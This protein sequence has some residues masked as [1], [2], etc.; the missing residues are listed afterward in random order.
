VASGLHVRLDAPLPAELAVGA[1]S[2]VFVAGTCHAGAVPVSAIELLVDGEPQPVMAHGMPRIDVLREAGAPAAYRSG[3]WA[4]ARLRPRA[5]AAPRILGIRARLRDG[6]TAEAEL[7]RIHADALPAPVAPAAR[8]PEVAICMATY[9]PPLALFRA[10]IESIRAQTH[11]DWLCVISDDGSSPA[12]RATI[13][14]VVGEDPR[15]V[16]TRAPRRLGFYRNFER[17]LA[18][19]PEGARYVALAD[20]DDRW[21]PDKLATLVAEIG[22]ARLAYSDARV[23]RP[24]GELVAETYWTQRTHNHDDMDALLITNS[25]TGAASLFPRALLDDALP[26]PADQF[27]HFHDHWLA[28]CALATGR[29]HYVARPLYDY[30]QHGEAFVGHERANRMPGLVERIPNLFRD[31]RERARVWR[32]H[33][34]GD[35]CRLMQFT[36]MLE[37]RCG[38]RLRPGARRALQRFERADRSRAPLGRLA[39]LGARELIGLRKETLGGEWLF[40]HA[41]AWR[42]L[43]GANA[44]DVPQRVARLDA[45]PPAARDPTPAARTEAAAAVR[46][47]EDKIAPLRIAVRAGAPR[48]VNLLVPTIDLAHFFGGYIGK[49]NLARRLAERGA[50]VRVVTVDPTGPLPPGW[51]RELHGYDGLAGVLDR[52]ELAFGR[53]ADAVEAS[54]EDAWIATTWWTAHVAHAAAR[55]TGRERFLYLIQEHE[56]F[57]FPMGSLAALADGSYALPHAAVYSTE[58]LRGYHREHGIGVFADSAAAGDARSTSFANA[59]T[60]V[61]PPAAGEMRARRPRRLLFYARPEPHAARNMFELGALALRRAAATG[62]FADDWTLHGIGTTGDAHEVDLG[63]VT[64]AMRPR[65]AQTGYAD[66]LREHDVGLALMYTPHPSLV[67]LEM[68]SAGLVTVTNSFAGKTADALTA[69]SSN[70]RCAPPTV[71]GIADAL[72]GAT[73]AAADVEA[74][75]AG[76]RVRWSRDWDET[77]SDAVM[78][79]I[80]TLLG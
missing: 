36:A 51:R 47:L 77:F 6:T 75:L 16:V 5:G 20:Q 46:A 54:P 17:A 57:T 67:P 12:G 59:I 68:A 7:G 70:L 66:V 8:A 60:A 21:H 30:V 40:L 79:R 71:E 56:T 10:Q 19:A 73:A 29:I 13:R 9:E 69:L 4:M 22:D 33:Y 49:F 31:P 58:L 39:V 42:H 53:E 63:G 72:C 35:A 11:R 52:V 1:G 25:V 24:G 23:I 65:A 27:E 44:R 32:M 18:L 78:E 64:L 41:F 3:F 62:A 15:F 43:I 37:L 50:R 48:R 14:D 38:D 80:E 76:S 74:R 26:F 2:A 61:E 55:A 28:V 45:V 34:F